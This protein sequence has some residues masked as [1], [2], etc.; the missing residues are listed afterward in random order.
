MPLIR[1][2]N[3]SFVPFPTRKANLFRAIEVGEIIGVLPTELIN[4]KLTSVK[5][6]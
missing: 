2:E 3:E 1:R 5:S 6:Y 4:F